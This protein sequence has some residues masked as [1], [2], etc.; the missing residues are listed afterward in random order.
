MRNRSIGQGFTHEA[1]LLLP[2]PGETFETGLAFNPRVNRYG[3]VA[4]GHGGR[5]VSR[6]RR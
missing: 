1:P 6:C 4:D 3:M 2:L 5:P